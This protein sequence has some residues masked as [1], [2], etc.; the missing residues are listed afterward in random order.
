MKVAFSSGEREVNLGDRFR[1]MLEPEGEWEVVR[2]PT[3]T[4]YGPSGFGGTPIFGCKLVS[5]DM[6]PHYKSYVEP[7]GTID[8]CGDS[9][10][11][12]MHWA[13]RAVSDRAAQGEGT[14]Q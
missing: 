9:I 8:F 5:G 2:M 6:P 4:M 1:L 14:D 11:A 12:A 13:D 10:A 7:D 3:R